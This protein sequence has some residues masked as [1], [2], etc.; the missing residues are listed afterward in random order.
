MRNNPKN[1]YLMCAEAQEIQEKWEPQTGDT[2][3]INGDKKLQI[4]SFTDDKNIHFESKQSYNIE[5]CI[6]IPLIEQLNKYLKPYGMWFKF[7][8]FVHESWKEYLQ[9]FKSQEEL[10]LAFVMYYFHKKI[11]KKNQ[12]IIGSLT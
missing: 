7:Y 11:W 5:Q 3:K 4:I 2:V 1:Y 8:K 10:L 9:T 12:W 6:W